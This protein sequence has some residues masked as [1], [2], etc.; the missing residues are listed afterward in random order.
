MIEKVEKYIEDFI[1]SVSSISPFIFSLMLAN[2]F[3]GIV[4]IKESEDDE[5]PDI[6]VLIDEEYYDIF[7]KI[8]K[9]LI[10]KEDYKSLDTMPL[11]SSVRFY[12]YIKWCFINEVSEDEMYYNDIN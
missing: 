12:H 6:V 1:S 8:D 10:T 3:K 7:G 2:K 11:L 9:Y 5:L 4:L